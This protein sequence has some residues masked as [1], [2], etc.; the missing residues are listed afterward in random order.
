MTPE[1]KWCVEK[2]NTYWKTKN[3]SLESGYMSLGKGACHQA[4]WP[5]LD[6]GK[7]DWMQRHSV[8]VAVIKYHNHKQFGE[9]RI[10]F[11]L[12]VAHSP[13]S[14]KSGQELRQNP[15]RSAAYWLLPHWFLVLICSSLLR[16]LPYSTQDHQLCPHTPVINLENDL[17]SQLWTLRKSTC[18]FLFPRG[19]NQGTVKPKSKCIKFSAWRLRPTH[20]LPGSKGF[21]SLAVRSTVHLSCLLGSGQLILCLVVRY[22][23]M[24]L[25]SIQVIVCIGN[26]SLL[27][28]SG[29]PYVCLTIHMIFWLLFS[30]I[31]LVWPSCHT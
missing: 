2:N 26:V 21:H 24:S 18:S 10:Y 3:N 1:I 30:Q 5:E 22:Q 29:I 19:T 23:I 9:E 15:W 17:Q 4:P 25:R 12:T 16:L 11:S 28:L 14:G 31:R 13:S 7:G 27:L 8:S 20:H 6:P